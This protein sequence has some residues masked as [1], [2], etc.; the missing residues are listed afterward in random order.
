MLR[1]AAKNHARVTVLSDPEDYPDFL[2][3]LSKGEIA[4]KSRQLYALKVNFTTYSETNP[5]TQNRIQAFEHTAS[6]DD[7]ISGFFRK[8]YAADGTQQLALRYGTNPHQKPA[9][10]FVKEGQLPIKVLC[11]AP[12]YVNLLDS[13]N[14]WPL[15]KELKKAL[16]MPAAASFKHVSPAGAAVGVSMSKQEQE[17]CMVDD[18]KGLEQSALAQAYARA[19]GSD[20]VSSY[21]DVIALSDE[22]DEVT[23]RVISRE[24]SDGIIAPAFTAKALEILS[25]KKGG[26]YLVLQVDEGYEPQGNETRTVYGMNLQQQRNDIQ[27]SPKDTFNTVVTPKDSTGLPAHASRD[28][29]VATIALKYTQ[30]NSVC[31]ALNGQVI[32]LGAGQQSRIHCTRLAGAKADN[33]W[34]R[35]HARARNIKW[36]PGVKRADKTNAIDLLCS[37][38]VPRQGMEK[39]EYE[40]LFEEVPAEFSAEERTDWMEELRKQDVVLASDAFF[41][42]IDNVQRATRSGV[43]YIAAPMG[44]QADDAVIQA[45]EAAKP[46]ICYVDQKTRLFHH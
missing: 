5:L 12:G 36:K 25:R 21:G 8:K 26:K 35:N 40:K 16:N 31:Y 37:D 14:A 19:R 3:E 17:V 1:A 2:Q 27:I 28:L 10:V 11:G 13:L 44:S 33:W 23:A 38:Q 20:R 45:C 30:S 39:D 32:G 7:A 6:Y 42:F 24:V 9:S 22:V 4:E 29:T 18:I 43:K 15:V 46:P 34:M 41:P